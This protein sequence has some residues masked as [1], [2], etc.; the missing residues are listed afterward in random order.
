MATVYIYSLKD[1]RDYSLRYIGKTIDVNR[2]LRE[3]NQRHRNR[4]SKKN[5]WI[6]SLLELGLQ[7][8]M[9]I[10]EECNDADWQAKER[11]WIEYYRT[12]GFDLKNMTSGGEDGYVRVHSEETKKKMSETRKKKLALSPQFHSDKTKQKLSLIAKE[13]TAGLLNLKK[14]QYLGKPIIQLTKDG[15]AIRQ[16]KH[17]NE[18]SQQLHI[19][20]TNINHCLNNR[21]KSAGGFKWQYK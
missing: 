19:E 6:I 5:S 14:G 11:H 20:R 12:I 9:E 13:N 10:L 18:A 17:A 4:V 3:H 16:W 1:P 21:M 7:P 2:R 8:I 15:I